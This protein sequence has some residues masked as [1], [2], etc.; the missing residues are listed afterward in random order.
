MKIPCACLLLVAL[1]ALAPRAAQAVDIDYTVTGLTAWN[2]FGLNGQGAEFDPTPDRPFQLTFNLSDAPSAFPPIGLQV[3]SDQ[4]TFSGFSPTHAFPVLSIAGAPP[5]ELA[6]PDLAFYLLNPATNGGEDLS[7]MSGNPV[8]RLGLSFSGPALF[9]YANGQASYETGTF[10]L[11]GG[12][13]IFENVGISMAAPLADVVLTAQPVPE[14]PSWLLV[15]SCAAGVAGAY[16][17]R[18]GR[19]RPA[20]SVPVSLQ[21]RPPHGP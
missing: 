5:N 17:V 7:V 15:A 13:E 14:G 9:N 20:P 4:V 21:S 11:T 3:T 1:S 16:G 18:R 12:L 8:F 19:L 2:G 10:D 6:G